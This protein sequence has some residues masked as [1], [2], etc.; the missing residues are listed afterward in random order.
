MNGKRKNHAITADSD[1]IYVCGGWR[2]YPY[3]YGTLNECEKYSPDKG[4]WEQMPEMT[5]RRVDFALVALQG[6]R[7]LAMGR[8]KIIILLSYFKA[9]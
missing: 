4:F 3:K 9:A 8:L 5:E 1:F 2:G 6:G 7:L